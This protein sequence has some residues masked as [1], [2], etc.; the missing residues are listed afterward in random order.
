MLVADSQG[1]LD[2]LGVDRLSELVPTS[3][4]AP[5]IFM[6]LKDDHSV[7]LYFL[8]HVD[9]KPQHPRIWMS[10]GP[11]GAIDWSTLNA[12][13]PSLQD[14]QPVVFLN[15]CASAAMSPQRLLSLI[16]EFFLYGVG[17]AVGT[18]I[19]VFVD[20]AAFFADEALKRYADGQALSQSLRR[21]RIEGLRQMNPMGFAY[22]GFGL[23]DLRLIT[24]PT[25]T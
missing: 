2:E 20:F 13:Q 23:H 17:G 4:T 25:A 1:E 7:L 16:D 10:N 22:I 11:D 6:S 5:P 15:A 9:C 21:A 24:A 3:I 19:T 12:A 8:A 18:E 14:R